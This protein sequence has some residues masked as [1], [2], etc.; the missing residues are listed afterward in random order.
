MTVTPRSMN[1]SE[2]LAFRALEVMPGPHSNLPGYE[3]FKPIWIERG[4]GAHLWDADGNEYLDYMC[5]L[6][7]GNAGLRQPDGARRD[8]CP[9]RPAAVPR[10]RAAQ[11][12]RDRARREDHRAHPERPEGALPAVG[13]RGRA[14]RLRLARAT[15]GAICSSASTATTT[16]GW[17]T[18]SAVA[19]I[20]TPPGPPTRCTARTTCSHR[21]VA[22]SRPRSSRSSCPGTTSRSSSGR[23]SN[24]A[25]RSR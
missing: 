11:P 13:K 5:G 2:R 19:S 20:R 24:T 23:S 3:L 16:A 22:T 7:A 8:P 10:R 25:T 15:R 12:G 21:R 1:S 18:C 9:A 17:T 6:G 4:E 14:A